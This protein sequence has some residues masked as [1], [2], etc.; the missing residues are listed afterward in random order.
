MLLLAWHAPQGYFRLK[1]GVS[2]K[3]LCGVASTASY[4]TKV[5]GPGAGGCGGSC[6]RARACSQGTPDAVRRRSLAAPLCMP[7]HRLPTASMAVAEVVLL[8][9]SPSG[10]RAGGPWAGCLGAAAAGP[11]CIQIWI[12]THRSGV[13]ASVG[14]PALGPL[15]SVGSAQQQQP[16]APLPLPSAPLPQRQVVDTP[17]QPS[18]ELVAARCCP[19]TPRPPPCR[20]PLTSQCPRCA[21]SLAGPSAL[22]PP[23]A[24]APLSCSACC[25]CGGC[26]CG[27]GPDGS[28][29]GCGGCGLSHVG[30]VGCVRVRMHLT[31][32][33]VCSAADV[34][35]AP[36]AE[37]R[38]HKSPAC[39]KWCN[40]STAGCRRRAQLAWMPRPRPHYTA[41]LHHA[42]IAHRR[43]CP[44]LGL[45]ACLP[46]PAPP[47][48]PPHH[49][50]SRHDCCPLEHGVTC[51]DLQHCCPYGT[52]CDQRQG[53]ELQG[54]GG[55]G[56]F[57]A[58]SWLHTRRNAAWREPPAATCQGP[59]VRQGLKQL[60]GPCQ[61]DS[62][63]FVA[64]SCWLLVVRA[65]CV[66]SDGSL[67][68]PW[69]SKT[70]AKSAREGRDALPARSGML[71]PHG[72]QALDE[73]KAVSS[74]RE[75]RKGRLQG[76]AQ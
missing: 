46:L 76:A 31:C 50:P 59:G 2:E 15:G 23:H 21:T 27:A 57:C 33:Q 61:S 66:S 10:P 7:A 4:P 35:G 42:S 43:K 71:G 5:G 49:T 6:V 22:R 45:C 69:S 12:L 70:K 47:P 65:A 67:V 20:P 25:A 34:C 30:V 72:M 58:G 32:L 74:Y 60:V 16:L 41:S 11:S 8:R 14:P 68:G 48:M 44:S 75:G 3:G 37:G 54:R 36:E 51:S 39:L 55:C 9:N 63:S 62:S 28:D 40:G 38:T 56:C 52:T 1:M 73:Q 18:G 24:R 29:G 19:P 13:F 26:G 53:G 17:T 64:W